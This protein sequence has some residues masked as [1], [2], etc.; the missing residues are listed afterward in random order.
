MGLKEKWEITYQFSGESEEP[1]T[2]G[3]LGGSIAGA[4]SDM[5]SGRVF[6]KKERKM[7]ADVKSLTRLFVG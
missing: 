4:V 7:A 5:D 3:R 1:R 6:L 2:V